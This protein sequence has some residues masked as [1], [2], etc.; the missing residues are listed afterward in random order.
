[1][2]FFIHTKNVQASFYL[3]F[4]ART[5]R[6]SSLV[7]ADLRGGV[8]LVLAGLAAEGTTE[9]NGVSHIDR[10]YQNL[11]GRLQLLG[12]DIKISDSSYLLQSSYT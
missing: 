3:K 5:L 6:G 12:A 2:M 7:A 10:G 9:I 4:F 8:S 11:D 1:M